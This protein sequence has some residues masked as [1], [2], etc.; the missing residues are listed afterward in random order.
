M[1]VDTRPQTLPFSIENAFTNRLEGGNAAAIVRVPSLTALP[2]A[3]LQV[4]ATNFNQP[5]S[6]F[7]AP[8]ETDASAS[9]GA[10]TFGIRW[11]TT[12]LEVPLCGHGTLAAAAAVFRSAEAVQSPAEI[13]F[14]APTGKFLVA[15]RVDE[16]RIEIDLDAGYSEALA[17]AEDAQLRDVLGRALGKNVRVKYAGRGIAHMDKYALIE[18][19]T[20][21]LKGLEVDTD[22]LVSWIRLAFKLAS[23]VLMD[24]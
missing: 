7:I 3:T 23:L 19:D 10:V 8:H 6:V 21:D 24:V 11:F 4:I 14:E 2:D 20:R 18:V 5:M 9:S 13:R 17:G 16:G 12:E 22:A 1:T 15:R